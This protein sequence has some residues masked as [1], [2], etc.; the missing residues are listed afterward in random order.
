[1]TRSADI[2]I[3][4][5]GLAGASA[6]VML[7]RTDHRV[8]MIDLHDQPR[9]EFRCEKL[10]PAQIGLLQRMGLAGFVLP[11]ATHSPEFWVARL[12]RLADKLPVSQYGAQYA[13]LVAAMRRGI[14]PHV[15]QL[16]GCVAGITLG[17]SEQI[18]TL[19]D[20]ETITARLVVLA[21]GLNLALRKSLG[22]ECQT[23]SP[24][25]SVTLGFD[26]APATGGRFRFDSLTYYGE[27]PQDRVAYLTLFRIGDGMRANLMTYL[28]VSDP[29]LKLFREDPHAAL[30]GLLPKLADLIG[31][32]EIT[33]EVKVRPA[34]LYQTTNLAQPGVVLV[35]DAFSTSC[36]AAGT[37]THKV[38]NDV[39]RLCSVHVPQWL[40]TAGMGADKLASFYEDPQKRAVDR[41]SIE[42]AHALKA[43]SLADGPRGH[44]AAYLRLAVR[45]AKGMVRRSLTRL[46]NTSRREALDRAGE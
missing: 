18:V 2:V 39:E 41:A 36:P 28:D 8:I 11:A 30:S 7:G 32:F 17:E 43:R 15:I 22:F 44:I 19:A 29:R 25:H 38:L 34:D 42:E 5:G 46:H 1:M 14:S 9:P 24:H 33:G 6:A 45:I 31:P 37:G 27:K 12:G 40:A 23:L 26:I 10:G 3:V 35:G 21:N 13:T 20:G 16:I 4:G